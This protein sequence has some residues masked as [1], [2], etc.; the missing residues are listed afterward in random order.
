[1][2]LPEPSVSKRS[3]ASRI[4]CFCSSDNPCERPLFLSRLAAP[5]PLRKLYSQQKTQ[6]ET[7]SAH[8]NHTSIWI[9]LHQNHSHLKISS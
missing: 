2:V 5:T 9:Y 4:S 1:M 8:Q 3:K 6:E 7:E